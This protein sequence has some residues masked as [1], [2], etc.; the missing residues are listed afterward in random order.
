MK[1][2]APIRHFAGGSTF[3]FWNKLVSLKRCLGYLMIGAP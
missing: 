2:I 1:H 3:P